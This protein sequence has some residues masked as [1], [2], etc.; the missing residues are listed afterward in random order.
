MRF[1]G[2][3]E[4][5]PDVCPAGGEAEASVALRGVRLIR[6]ITVAADDAGEVCGD[7]VAQALRAAAGAPHEHGI[8]LGLLERPEVALLG[9]TISR[10]QILDHRFIDLHV[11]AGHDAG[12]DAFI[13]WCEPLCGKCEPACHALPG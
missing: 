13:K 8:A 4:L 7:D 9:F 5:A 11:A 2:F 10:L 1:F 3:V 6:L 12:V